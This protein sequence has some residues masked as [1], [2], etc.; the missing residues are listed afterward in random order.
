MSVRKIIQ[1]RSAKVNIIFSYECY[2]SAPN[3]KLLAARKRQ[4]RN[5][6]FDVSACE[7]ASD[8]KK[9]LMYTVRE[10]KKEK[11]RDGSRMKKKTAGRPWSTISCLNIYEDGLQFGERD[12]CV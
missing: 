10:R 6:F 12:V 1:T 4:S 9:K 2:L 7:S 11:E 5:E 8:I 3:K